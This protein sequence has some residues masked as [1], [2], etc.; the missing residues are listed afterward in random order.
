MLIPIFKEHIVNLR[1]SPERFRIEDLRLDFA[2]LITSFINDDLFREQLKVMKY[3]SD[4]KKPLRYALIMIEHMF[5]W[6]NDSRQG[7]PVCRD[8]TRVIDFGTITLEH[9]EATNAPDI[10]S[11]LRPFVNSIGNL[12]VMS[13]LENNAA[14]NSSFEQKRPFFESSSLAMNREI[15]KIR[16]WNVDSYRR[17]E[18]DL[19]DRLLAIFSI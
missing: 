16:T 2:A 7:T 13:Q 15:A 4:T 11:D 3:G 18:N 12:T 8:T 9:I 10:D 19:L 1:N 5:H 14:A 17:R 6:C